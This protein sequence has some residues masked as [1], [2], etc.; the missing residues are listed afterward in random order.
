MSL[1]SSIQMA[2]NALQANDICLQVT[3]QNISNANTPG[4]ICEEA[5]LVASAPEREGNLVL[6]TGVLVQSVTENIDAFLDQRLRGATSDQS[7]A[8]SL[9]TTYSQL[10]TIVGA[11]DNSNLGTAMSSFFSSINDILNQ[12]GDTSVRNLA[13]LQGEDLATTINQLATQVESLR[14]DTNT[15]VT[16]MA[17]EINSLTSQIGSLNLQIEN[18]QGGDTSGSDAVGLEDQRLQALQ[19]LSQL[20]GIQT[21]QQKN[22][23]ISVSVGGE[24]LVSDG[25]V[26]S[27]KTNESSNGGQTVTTL[28]IAGTNTPLNASSGELAGLLQA[29]DTVLPGFLNN[30]NSFA[31]TLISEFNKVYSSGQGLDGFTTVTSESAVDDPNAALNATGLNFTPTSGSF[32]VLVYD[33]TTG[34]TQ[35]NNIN[36]NL[37]GQGQDMT[38]PQLAAALNNISGISASIG[39]DNRL[40]ITSTSPN[41]EFSFANDTS[42]VLTS[43]G[44]N[45]FFSGSTALDMGVNSYVQNDPSLFAASQGGIGA[46]TDNAVQLAT[47][48]DAPLASQN[49]NSITDLYN[50]MVN[51]VTQGSAQAQSTAASADAYATSLSSQELAE[52]GVSI[53]TETIKMLG[54]QEA[55][56][57]SAKYIST[58]NG[59]LQLL[60]QL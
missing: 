29:R 35:T 33:K 51:N 28:C 58:L 25:V 39:T 57:A 60:T 48:A 41:Q 5:N 37:N 40:T 55:Y 38:L 19:S 24:F 4:Y 43:L 53:D 22:G 27:V 20:I 21:T 11:I 10:E 47:F 3:G 17:S 50:N 13:V 34:L 6:G 42:G 26:R 2:G 12:P 49:G 14:S 16:N 18:V 8:D 52:S 31:G 59:L 46:D 32:Q 44:I 30:L 9:K 1:F 23:S 7:S 54:Y 15:Y 56:Q 36:V 45:T